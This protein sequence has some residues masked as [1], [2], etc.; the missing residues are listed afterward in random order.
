LTL[1]KNAIE[2]YCDFT[3]AKYRNFIIDKKYL[4]TLK[5]SGETLSLK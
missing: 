4:S 5:I 3:T 1:A 2:K